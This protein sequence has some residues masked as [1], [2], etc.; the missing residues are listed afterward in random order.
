MSVGMNKLTFIQAHPGHVHLRANVDDM[1]I[2]VTGSD[3]SCK[4]RKPIFDHVKIP[5]YP[6]YDRAFQAQPFVNSNMNFIQLSGSAVWI[7][8][9]FDHR[10]GWA[11]PAH[12]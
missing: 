6:V 4:D 3:L 1:D 2:S 7:I 11:N 10:D 8:Y 5:H 9:I 12:H